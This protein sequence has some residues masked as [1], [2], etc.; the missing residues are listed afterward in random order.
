MK[1]NSRCSVRFHLLVPGG[2]CATVTARPVSVA[3][4]CSSRFHSRRRA[5][6]AAAIGGDDQPLSLGV[7]CLA[8]PVP[9]APDALDREGGRVGIDP[10]LRQG[11][12]WKGG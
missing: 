10:N 9:P 4:R 2:R 7:A 5:V 1:A 8:E 11:K 6:A 3:K 12:P